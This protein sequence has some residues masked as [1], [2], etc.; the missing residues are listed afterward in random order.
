MM[1]RAWMMFG[2]CIWDDGDRWRWT[3][4]YILQ[5]GPLGQK[6]K[7]RVERGLCI[8]MKVYPM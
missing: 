4:F 1:L 5:H 7:V 3:A 6:A 8:K 2:F